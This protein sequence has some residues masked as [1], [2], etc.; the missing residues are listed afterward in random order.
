MAR[1]KKQSNEPA[2]AICMYNPDGTCG[3]F[4]DENTEVKTYPT[5]EEAEKSLKQLKRNT[6]YSWSLP[7]EVKEFKG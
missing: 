1:P 6:K 5:Q 3:W 7:V 4:V 2:W